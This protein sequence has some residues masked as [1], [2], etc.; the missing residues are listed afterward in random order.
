MSNNA[1]FLAFKRIFLS[2]LVFYGWVHKVSIFCNFDWWVPKIQKKIVKQPSV[3][4]FGKKD[5]VIMNKF[6]YGVYLKNHECV[7]KIVFESFL[8]QKVLYLDKNNNFK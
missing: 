5:P 3:A 7:R 1:F 8:H 4:H 6:S 2:R